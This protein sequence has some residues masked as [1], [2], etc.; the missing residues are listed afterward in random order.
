[1]CGV[2]V[3][4]AAALFLSAAPGPA[5]SLQHHRAVRL[6][7]DAADGADRPGVEQAL[8]LA[9][10]ADEAVVIAD[11]GDH[12][13]SAREVG[14]V[15]SVPRAQGQ[16]LLAEDGQIPL[17]RE[18]HHVHVCA[19]RRCDQ[20]RVEVDVAEHRLVVTVGGHSRVLLEHAE[21]VARRVADRRNLDLG[22]RVGDREVRHA[23]LA[24]PDDRELDHVDP[25]LRQAAEPW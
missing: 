17:K 3:E 5:L 9:E 11:L 23:H 19:G 16:R 1:M 14:Q 12:S 15:L 13:S 4:A 25:R 2:V 7:E 20:H 22:M 8:D 10:A 21:D 6:A 24:E 18:T